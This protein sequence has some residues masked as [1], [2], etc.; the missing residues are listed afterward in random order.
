[1]GL[2]ENASMEEMIDGLWRLPRDIVSD[3]YD[4]ALFALS[5]QVPMKIHE[6]PTG[7][8]CFTWI[9]PE[10][11]T[12]KEAYLE[13]LDGH[14]VF[15]YEDNPLHVVSYSLPVDEVV[16]RKELFDHLHTHPKLR[17]AI[18]FC[19]KYYD[20]DWGLCCSED[21][22]ATLKNDQYRVVIRSEFSKGT[23]KVGEVFLPG[24]SDETIVLSAH[25]CHPAMVN[26]DLTGIV[27]GIDVM[28][29]LLRA[30]PLRYSYRYLIVPETIGTL[31]YLSHN[32]DLIP[33]MK[34][35]LFLEALGR[36]FPF[37]LQMSFKGDTEID[38]C[39]TR[40]I[41]DH[42]TNSWTA[43]LWGV[44]CNDERQYNAPG[45][46]VPML[47]L[48]RVLHRSEPDG[49]YREYH[50]NLDTPDLVP[51]KSLAESRDLVM[52]MIYTLEN[53][54]VP[55]NKFKGEIFC[56]RYGIKFDFANELENSMT[57]FDI[58]FQLDNGSSLVEI[59]DICNKP[60]EMVKETVDK[61]YRNG[62]VE[63]KPYSAG[64]S[65]VEVNQ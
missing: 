19:F 8:E 42:A 63:L 62:L 54:W 58:M 33:S 43:P 27:V 39:F 16:S 10:K 13:T 51:L 14:R 34:G 41:K 30:K 15:S 21:L 29:R 55:V 50:S 38:R 48:S 18:P 57:L 31:A 46:R 17:D 53:N 4:A 1:M 6:Y 61:F 22:K 5:G 45:I 24:E 32:E 12:C 40:A 64:I 9:V 7:A 35:G 23:L 49:P 60:F 47:S 11:W 59:A 20:R 25:L 2:P 56:S 44:I 3:G 28:R 26:D 52:K 36:D 37:A 65:S